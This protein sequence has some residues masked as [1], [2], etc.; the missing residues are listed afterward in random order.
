MSSPGRPRRFTIGMAG[1]AG[2]DLMQAQ[3]RF[4]TCD[5]AALASMHSRMLQSRIFKLE[6]SEG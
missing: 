3:S 6:I 1:Q 2:P 4:M 5:I